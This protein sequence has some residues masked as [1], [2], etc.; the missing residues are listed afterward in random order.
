MNYILVDMCYQFMLT[1][2]KLRFPSFVCHQ[3]LRN[4]CGS[5]FSD[6]SASPITPEEVKADRCGQKQALP[7]THTHTLNS[8]NSH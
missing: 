8:D 7:H 6:V 3:M 2:T 5:L 1:Y 4:V